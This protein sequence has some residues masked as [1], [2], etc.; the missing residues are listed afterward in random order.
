MASAWRSRVLALVFGMG[1]AAAAGAAVNRTDNAPSD[2]YGAP[3][4]APAPAPK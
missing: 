3:M 4:M 1:E 2:I